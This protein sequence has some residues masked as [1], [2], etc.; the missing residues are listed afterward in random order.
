VTVCSHVQSR[1]YRQTAILRLHATNNT[2][3][4]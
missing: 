4:G 2:Y 3:G 1:N